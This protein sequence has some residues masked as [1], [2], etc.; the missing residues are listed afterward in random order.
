[1]TYITTL[2]EFGGTW[3]VIVMS[4]GPDLLVTTRLAVNSSRRTALAAV[5][6]IST[7]T[8]LW[9]TMSATGIA[10]FLA[11]EQSLVSVIRWCGAAYLLFLAIQVFRHA[12]APLDQPSPTRG[13]M[14]DKADVGIFTAWRTGLFTDLSNPKAAV[15]WSS[16][17]AAF[18][19]KGSPLWLLTGV[20]VLAVMIAGCWYMVA[21]LL[22]S[23]DRVFTYY[24]K[25]KRSIDYITGGVL[26]SLAARLAATR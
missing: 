3:G 21:A 23:L 10:V 4:P 20:V 25:A 9:A 24:K 2:V 22:L 19:P 18:A 6:G 12:K 5:G 15:F 7:G 16:L 11:Q 14:T 1:V 8:A 26:I 13:E 17:F